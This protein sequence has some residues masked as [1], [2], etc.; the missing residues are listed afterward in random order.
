[1]RSESRMIDQSQ[2]GC[3]QDVGMVRKE[4]AERRVFCCLE[5]GAGLSLQAHL[6]NS[7]P[8]LRI[9]RLGAGCALF[10][11]PQLSFQLMAGA[12]GIRAD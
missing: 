10:S 12:L 5:K 6:E 8:R 7:K 3:R 9:C 4:P 1:M 2:G 11:K